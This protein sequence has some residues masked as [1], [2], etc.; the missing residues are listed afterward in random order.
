MENDFKF[1]DCHSHINFSDYDN[2]REDV[3]N[4]AKDNKVYILDVGTDILSSTKSKE[5]S[6]KLA[7]S[8]NGIK[9]IVGIHPEA[10]LS[11]VSEFDKLAKMAENEVVV[12]IGECGLDYFH[13]EFP[14]KKIQLDA[15]N[16]QKELSIKT[17]KP[18]MI[19]VRNGRN[20]EN[21]FKDILESLKSSK[22][23]LVGGNI[24]FFSGSWEE[25]RCFFDLGF[26][27]SF[28]GVITFTHDYDEIISN[29]PMDMILSETD[30]PFV[31]PA[32]FRGK[33]N[34]PSNV[35]YTVKR[36][37]EIKNISIEDTSIEIMKNASR[38]FKI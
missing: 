34:E 18:L 16:L 14:E 17:K 35:M 4:R 38:I 9:T 25:A 11:I 23:N 8:Y 19:H 21:A 29:S 22:N 3:I 27:V 37:S 30:S 15:F 32:P 2:D 10:S 26:S 1:I 6:E 33:R 5:L 28:T 31:S 12:G 24:H 13:A 7:N 36:I 20:D